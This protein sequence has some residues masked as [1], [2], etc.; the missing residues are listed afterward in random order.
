MISFT[1]NRFSIS[2]TNTRPIKQALPVPYASLGIHLEQEPFCS[3]QQELGGNLKISIDFCQLCKPMLLELY[4]HPIQLNHNLNC[5]MRDPKG[6]EEIDDFA[7]CL[8]SSHLVQKNPSISILLYTVHIE[9]RQMV[10]CRTLLSCFSSIPFVCDVIMS[11]I[12]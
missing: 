3:M 10:C 5:G 7:K 11:H 9:A 2:F 8:W 4:L 6:G 1:K 12:L